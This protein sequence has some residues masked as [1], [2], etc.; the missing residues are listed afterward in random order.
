MSR[1]G[2]ILSR[3]T[4][5]LRRQNWFAVLL[6]ILI[7]TMGVLIGIQVSNWNDERREQRELENLAGR[8]LDDFRYGRDAGPQVADY[9]QSRIDLGKKA[10]ALWGSQ[11]S[12]L[13]FVTSAY[14]TG[15]YAVV[16][17][18]DETSY[19]LAVGADSIAK[20]DDDQLRTAIVEAISL[21]SDDY[22]NWSYV[23]SDFRR[24]VR[25]IY[26][27]DMQ[28]TIYDACNSLTE[29]IEIQDIST[30]DCAVN[31]STAEVVAVA[32]KLRADQ[33]ALGLLR[34]H[35]NRLG[36]A[37]QRMSNLG[38]TYDEA[39]KAIEAAQD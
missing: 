33:Q 3:L 29:S 21:R 15:S 9:Y 17:D 13:D 20:I 18:R 14:L 26:P 37:H 19:G 32:A 23:D 10:E 6:E 28:E 22:L 2:T 36:G 1:Q 31:L 7:V 25:R 16:L 24:L 38:A 4:D 30:T 11:G 8:L 12:D 35:I 5:A 27:S 34:E 39:V